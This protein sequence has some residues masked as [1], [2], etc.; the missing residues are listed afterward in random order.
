MKKRHVL[1]F[2]VLF[3]VMMLAGTVNAGGG[4]GYDPGGCGCNISATE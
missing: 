3:A 1:F 4:G 2:S